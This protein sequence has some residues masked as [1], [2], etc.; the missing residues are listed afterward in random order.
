MERRQDAR[1]PFS[2]SVQLAFDDPHPV[3]VEAE[4]IET[5]ERGFRATHHSSALAPGLEVH[6]S[7]AAASGRAR[8]IWTHVL[9][10]RWVSGF[11]ILSL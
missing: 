1:S 11:L 2:G 6:Y 8:V 4:L 5:S 3:I 10:G 7:R 9:E